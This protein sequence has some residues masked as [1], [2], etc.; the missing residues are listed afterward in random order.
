M[1]EIEV[2]AVLTV[3]GAA[4]E[5]TGVALIVREIAAD[6]RM[7]REVLRVPPPEPENEQ[8]KTGPQWR[9]VLSRR[10]RI[11]WDEIAQ[12]D[13]KRLGEALAEATDRL[14]EADHERDRTL[15]EFLHEQLATGVG[16]RLVGV[17]FF[18]VGI[19]STSIS[20]LVQI[21]GR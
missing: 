4:C 8:R 15:R 2:V 10:L 5:L 12:V 11:D 19:I 14:I 17:G 9:G 20:Q 7:A 1:T 6:R 21:R 3:T 16:L 13:N 18:V